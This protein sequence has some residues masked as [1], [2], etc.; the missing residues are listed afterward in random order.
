MLQTFLS[1]E[2]SGF[3][4][5]FDKIGGVFLYVFLI[6]FTLMFLYAM[7]KYVKR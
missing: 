6:L 5:T 4:K 2:V 3:Y 7:V 1:V